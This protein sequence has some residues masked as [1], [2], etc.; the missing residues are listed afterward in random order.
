MLS[1]LQRKNI[2]SVFDVLD[3][4]GSGVITRADF[5]AVV[6]RLKSALH[7]PEGSP[8]AQ[9]LSDGYLGWWEQIRKQVDVDED[10]RITRDEYID[11]VDQGLLEDSHYLDAVSAAADSLFGAADA[12][13]DG[14]LVES[15]MVVVYGSV[16]IDPGIAAGAFH[17]IDA[18]GD[19]RISRA[20][21]RAA[22]RGAFASKGPQE[23]G[24]NILGN[25][26]G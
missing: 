13:G 16:G 14:A 10:G 1:E 20:E 2:S 18:D 24:S 25:A 15:E 4:D 7:H 17:Q 8:Q 11:A 9:S 22:V 6:T 5:V 3:T 12:D 23:P 19:G 26:N 21:L